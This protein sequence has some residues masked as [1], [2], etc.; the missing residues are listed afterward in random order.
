MK[1]LLK[2]EVRL[3]DYVKLY[4]IKIIQE[5]KEKITLRLI[6]TSSNITSLICNKNS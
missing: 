1:L 6:V 4:N 5:G 3:R 2:K